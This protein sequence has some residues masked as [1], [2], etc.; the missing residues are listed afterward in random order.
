MNRILHRP[1]SRATPTATP[2]LKLGWAW[3]RGWKWRGGIWPVCPA[4]F[5]CL[6][7]FTFWTLSQIV[8]LNESSANMSQFQLTLSVYISLERVRVWHCW[9]P[10]RYSPFSRS[11][12]FFSFLWHFEVIEHFPPLLFFPPG[13]PSVSRRPVQWEICSLHHTVVSHFFVCRAIWRSV[14]SD[15][16][17]LSWGIIPASRAPGCLNISKTT[18]SISNHP[19]T[20]LL[21][22]RRLRNGYV[23]LPV[24][25]VREPWGFFFF[26]FF[27]SFHCCWFWIKK[28]DGLPAAAGQRR[29]LPCTCLGFISL[30]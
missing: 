1:R 26:C 8:K 23:R 2:R 14:H 27:Y 18:N 21:P 11:G 19:R 17:E 16:L 15:R 10:A 30:W 13:S 24:C 29:C 20:K 7:Y 28:E 4:E 25:T 5:S 12:S 9:G 6:L 22:T 3:N